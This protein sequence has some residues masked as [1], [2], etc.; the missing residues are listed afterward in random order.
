MRVVLYLGGELVYE[1][2]FWLGGV[3][4]VFF[5]LRV[6]VRFTCIFSLSF[7]FSLL[8]TGLVTILFTYIVL[9]FYI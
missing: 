5:F 6:V 3:C 1:F 2:F 4:I 7:Y 8:Y 9:Y